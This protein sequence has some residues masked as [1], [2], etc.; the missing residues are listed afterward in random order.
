MAQG[1]VHIKQEDCEW[2][3]AEGWCVKVEE[4]EGG[5]SLFKEEEEE[6]EEEP[7]GEVINIKV[8]EC[9]DLSIGLALQHDDTGSRFKQE[10]GDEFH[11][12]LQPWFTNMGPLATQQ[13]LVELKSEPEE[14]IN[15]GKWRRDVEEQQSSRSVARNSQENCSFSMSSLAQPSFQCRLQHQQNNGKKK[16]SKRG[17]ENLTAPSLPCSSIS[18]DTH[19]ERGSISTDQQAVHNT[20]QLALY[21]S[22]ECGQTFKN[23]SECNDGSIC[24]NQKPYA[25]SECGKLFSYRNS[26]QT[27]KMIHI[28]DKPY[29]CAECDKRYSSNSALQRHTRIHTGEKPYSCDKCGKRFFHNSSLYNHS[30]VHMEEKPYCCSECGKRFSLVGN[31]YDHLRIHSGEKP[32]C[33]SECGKQFTRV[34]SLRSHIRIHTG[35]KPHSCSECGKRFSRTSSLHFHSR[36]HTGEKPHSCSECGK[37]FSRTSSLQT[38][39]RIHTGERPYWCSEC[40]KRFSNSSHL[41]MH[42]RIHTGEKPYCCLVCGKLFA[43]LGNLHNHKKV[44]IGEKPY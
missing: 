10:I 16:N 34:S 32:Y 23:E 1:V 13:N 9:E 36:V 43:Q 24:T 44:H 18:A 2:V 4:C 6:E 27:H 17:S 20:N 38:H 7:M 28:G 35:E 25:C 37:R 39:T 11:S 40:G 8:E 21:S 33:C 15:E 41:Q 42:M 3:A 29:S 30:K 14:E 26:L 12:R 5:V 22:R 19:T 31:L